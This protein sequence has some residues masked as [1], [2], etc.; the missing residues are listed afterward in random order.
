MQRGERLTQPEA[1]SRGDIRPAGPAKPAA[2]SVSLRQLT[3]KQVFNLASERWLLKWRI[4][5]LGAFGRMPASKVRSP[6]TLAKSLPHHALHLESAGR[7]ATGG[8]PAIARGPRRTGVIRSR[9]G[10]GLL[11]CDGRDQKSP[12]T[13]GPIKL[14]LLTQ[15]RGLRRYAAARARRGSSCGS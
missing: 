15:P 3:R 14:A 8:L 4:P 2:R 13:R 12:A 7:C 9:P 10:F 1:H 5:A 6:L 11:D